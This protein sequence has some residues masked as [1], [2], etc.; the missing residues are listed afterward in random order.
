MAKHPLP[1]NLSVRE[2][3]V[4]ES[5]AMAQY[6]LASGMI[7]PP[8]SIATLEQ[9]RAAPAETSSDI[10]AIVKVHDQLSKLVAPATPR[11]LLLLGPDHAANNRGGLKA[12]LGSVGLV[13]RMMI[14]AIVSMVI[15][16][17]TGLT[18]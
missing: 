16:I 2:Q 18:P 6:A 9:A 10:A 11:A 1:A 17:G 3:L 8:A 4:H 13:R 12:M 5:V 14:A 15:Y 7:V